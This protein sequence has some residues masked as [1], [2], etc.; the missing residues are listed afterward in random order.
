MQACTDHAAAMKNAIALA[1][2]VYA[3]WKGHQLQM[4]HTQ[5]KSTDPSA[6]FN[7]WFGRVR[8]AQGPLAAYLAA[9]DAYRKTSCPA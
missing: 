5:E 9:S 6:Y 3:G 7:E 1:G 4:T 2:P 8:N